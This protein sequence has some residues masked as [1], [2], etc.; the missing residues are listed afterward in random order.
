MDADHSLSGTPCPP[1][2]RDQTRTNS[3]HPRRF[4][5]E[6]R[7]TE[8]LAMKVRSCFRNSRAPAF[9][10]VTAEGE[11]CA[12]AGWEE[13][14]AGDSERKTDGISVDEGFFRVSSLIRYLNVFNLRQTQLF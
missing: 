8:L 12:T 3:G 1:S 13:M 7:E 10:I 11:G 9:D 5:G 2:L 4:A 14:S 6:D